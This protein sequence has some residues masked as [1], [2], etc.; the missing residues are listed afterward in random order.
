MF[1]RLA[2]A[3]LVLLRNPLACV[4]RGQRLADIDAATARFETALL[5]FLL[6]AMLVWG[7]V[8]S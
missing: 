6:A 1:H 3:L 8:T 4:W 2:P 7:G 5:A